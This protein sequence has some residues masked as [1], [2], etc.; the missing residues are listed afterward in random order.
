MLLNNLVDEI[1]TD[2][3]TQQ[4]QSTINEKFM[5][6]NKNFLLIEFYKCRFSNDSKSDDRFSKIAKF[7]KM[8]VFDE[9]SFEILKKF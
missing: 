3:H 9:S 1:I 5:I 4:L 8:L 7:N 2:K 6:L